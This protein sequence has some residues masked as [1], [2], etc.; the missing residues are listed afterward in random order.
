MPGIIEPWIDLR[1]PPQAPEKEARADQ[2]QDGQ[3]H[4]KHHKG[5]AHSRA[6]RLVSGLPLHG[7]DRIGV[8]RLKSRGESKD[9]SGGDGDRKGE[10]EYGVVHGDIQDEGPVDRRLEPA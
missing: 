3:G 6:S 8:R 4:L 5:A 2:E 1:G 10:E 7:S 9:E